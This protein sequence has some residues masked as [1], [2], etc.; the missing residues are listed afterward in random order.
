MDLDKLVNDATKYLEGPPLLSNKEEVRNAKLLLA[1]IGRKEMGNNLFKGEEFEQAIKV[2]RE[3]YL[4]VSKIPWS[5]SKKY[6]NDAM[7][8]L[9]ALRLNLAASHTKLG[10][11]ERALEF[12]YYAI[13][14]R[15]D[16]NAKAFYRRG[17]AYEGLQNFEAAQ[18]D[19]KHAIQLT[20]GDADIQKVL[21]RVEAAL[22]AR[23][24]ESEAV[25][26]ARA[27]RERKKKQKQRKKQ[28]L[29]A[30]RLRQIEDE[31]KSKEAQEE[32][33]R[34]KRVVA[35]EE[36]ERRKKD[37][38][39]QEAREAREA[40]EL[41]RR[42]EQRAADKRR[43]A[44]EKARK[45]AEERLKQEMR[46][47]KR[48]EKQMA[49]ARA[50]E[51][52]LQKRARELEQLALQERLALQEAQQSS[53]QSQADSREA[54]ARE[55]QRQVLA[56]LQ[57]EGQSPLDG[58]IVANGSSIKI[59]ATTSTSMV[60]NGLQLSKDNGR[61]YTPPLIGSPSRASQAQFP[62]L[63]PNPNE[64][65]KSL[66]GSSATESLGD[67]SWDTVASAWPEATWDVQEDVQAPVNW[68]ITGQDEQGCVICMEREKNALLLPCGHLS[69]CM[70]CIDMVKSSAKPLCPI[71]RQ[72]IEDVIQ[73]S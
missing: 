37:L 19:L 73:I 31:K 39:A 35:A 40:E 25:K 20:G 11:F 49:E 26:A 7:K 51:L 18:A 16:A 9:E 69:A 3:A 21:D 2:F 52:A 38:L 60:E 45:K 62:R 50:Y 12:C 42:E 8:L 28:E 67:S 27:E 33:A 64:A 44:E 55:G 13:K 72:A 43:A 46:E 14:L 65:E 47:Q 66:V 34:R 17:M 61:P 71:C 63:L 58:R 22:A 4:D 24:A 36:A 10:N 57:K 30:A 23:A 41:R 32:E 29:E 56:H 5:E 15:P 1:N 53:V 59:P 68:N 70:Q 6:Y 54:A 48:K